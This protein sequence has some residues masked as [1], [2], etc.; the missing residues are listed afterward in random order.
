MRQQW[1]QRTRCNSGLLLMESF[2]YLGRLLSYDDNDIR[3]I[4]SNQRKARKCWAR[5]S[6]ALN[7]E[8][9]SPRVCGR[10]YV[11]MVQAVLL[12]GSETWNVTPSAM[13]RLEGFHVRAAWQMVMECKPRR[14][15]DGS[16]MYP[17]SEDV[18]KE[19]G[20]RSI[21]MYVE[22]QRQTIASFIVHRPIFD[23]C[24]EAGRLRGTSPR[25]WW[26]EQQMDLEE[27]REAA[28]AASEVGSDDGK[29][30]SGDE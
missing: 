11:A 23:F 27:A 15:L 18:L 9:A 5:I 16:W 19:V 29:D 26:W 6:R 25:Q 2:K 20:L 21:A 30:V 13:K 3:A 12:F 7:A 24:M 4:W 8:N 10:F 28:G 17:S 1:T 14:N 22:V